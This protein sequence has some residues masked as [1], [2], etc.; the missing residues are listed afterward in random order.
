MKV[1][2]ISDIHG[3]HYALEQVLH[4]AKKRGVTQLLVLG[5]IVGYYYHP[6]KAMALLS[7]WDYEFIKG[8]HEDM[9]AQLQNGSIEHEE[10]KKKYGSGHQL[11]LEK[12]S[13]EQIQRLISAPDKKHIKVEQVNLLMCHGANF[14]PGFY[15]YP[16]SDEEVLK[17]CDEPSMDFVLVGHSHYPFAYRNTNSTLINVG[18][19]GQSRKEGGIA[20][21]L[22]IN[23]SN[24]SFE[25]MSTPYDVNELINEVTCVDPETLYLQTVLKRRLL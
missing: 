2:V 11:A 6:D 9:L 15:L 12:L 8:N 3:N 4:V 18:S 19:V 23:T 5:D 7:D 13:K 10:L 14:D 22:I 17:K 20:N 1:G 24:K 21:W 25:M 16:D